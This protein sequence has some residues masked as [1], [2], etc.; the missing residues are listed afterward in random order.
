MVLLDSRER[1]IAALS[2]TATGPVLT[3]YDGNGAKRLNLSVTAQ[4]PAVG[5]VGAGG[6]AKGAFGMTRN[7]SCYLQLF[8]SHEHGGAQLFAAADR[9]TLR[10]LDSSDKTRAAF[11][12][13]EKQGTPGLTLNDA[14]ATARILL[15]LLPE[16]PL[17]NTL[18]Q[19]KN[20]TWHAP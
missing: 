16:G 17:L 11:G 8:G 5:L 3:L 18:D 20:V 6:E 7:E 15:M 4:G 9:A 19:N 13:L 2:S 12:L 1:H 14:N 10:F